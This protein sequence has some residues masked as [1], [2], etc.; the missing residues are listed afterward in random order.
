MSIED[1]ITM[2]QKLKGI[3]PRSAKRIVLDLLVS[4][5][6]FMP[7]LAQELLNVSEQ[8]ETCRRCGNV[9]I[10]NPCNICQNPQRDQ[11]TL[12]I[13]QELVDLWALEKT[14]QFNG[15]YFVLHNNCEQGLSELEPN[16]TQI[17]Q[18]YFS[19][20]TYNIK[21][22]I[23][24]TN[25]TI[26]GQTTAFFISEKLK[27]FDVKITRLAF[28]LPIGSELDFLDEAT[29]EAALKMRSEMEN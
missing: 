11:Q 7:Q 28:G 13:V 27:K 1:L 3:G 26:E 29:I 16:L 18:N 25:G 17:I 8:I 12:C 15:I 4:K 22:V 14:G 24:A 2:M 23:I 6:Q 19:N 21:E 9:D 5:K 20:N 10:C